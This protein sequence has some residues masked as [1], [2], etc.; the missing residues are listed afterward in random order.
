MLAPLSSDT[1]Q[2]TEVSADRLAQ[3]RIVAFVTDDAS[4]AALRA[5]LLNLAE[6]VE[7]RR[8]T[9]QQAIR[10]LEK[11]APPPTIVVDIDSTP[12]PQFALED[13]ARVCPPDVKVIVIG[14]ISDIGFYRILINELAVTEY[15]HKPLTRDNVQRLLLPHLGLTS[16][17]PTGSRGGSVVVV[18]GASGGAG[19]TTVALSCALEL[20]DVVKGHVAMLDLHLQGGTAAIMVSERP[21]HGL[22]SALENPERADALFLERTGIS[23]NPRLRLIAAEEP[24]TSSPAVTDAGVDKVLALLRQKFNF[25]VVDLPMPMPSSM[26][27]VLDVARHAVI[28]FGPDI[29]GL[30]DTQS[31]R[32]LI[33][34]TARGDRALTVLNRADLKGGLPLELIEKGLGARPDLIIPELGKR[35]VE[36]V[37][38]GVPAAQFVPALRNHLSPLIREI[39][40]TRASVSR[41]SWAAR[42]LGR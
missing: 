36:A 8:G 3:Q 12:D 21:G 10:A 37:N 31:I 6:E 14:E 1:C 19:A 13:L 7:V 40:G 11:E 38:K 32:Q 4:A 39:A 2:T 30:R 23:V 27:R 15:V 29:V 33:A 35:M 24:F 22:R 16:I 34:G 18:C 17:A 42:L 28:V 41:S 26:R 25:V 20:S 9:L 5:G